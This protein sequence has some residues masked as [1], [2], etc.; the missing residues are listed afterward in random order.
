[1]NG[2]HNDTIK[3]I[4]DLLESNGYKNL[5][6][7]HNIN[8]LKK[9]KLISPDTYFS[10]YIP[11]QSIFNRRATLSKSNTT[12]KTPDIVIE[13]NNYRY[14][15]DV[16]NPNDNA[17]SICRKIET[18][19]SNA[20]KHNIVGIMIIY[21][22]GNS[23]DSDKHYCEK[24][25]NTFNELFN[26]KNSDPNDY[27]KNLEILFNHKVLKKQFPYIDWERINK[28]EFNEIKSN[29]DI[30]LSEISKCFEKIKSILEE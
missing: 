28:I 24:L 14:V 1:M 25:Q 22:D 27:I 9:F 10:A 12:W 15:I 16:V 23:F 6:A 20:E 8:N 18:I 4:L 11:T 30:L 21:F 19:I 29:K 26:C 3:E 2:K 5:F 13:K 7:D 17:T